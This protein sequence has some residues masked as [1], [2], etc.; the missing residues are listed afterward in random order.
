MFAPA[1]R[2]TLTSTRPPHLSPVPFIKDS[3]PTGASA[4]WQNPAA[5]ALVSLSPEPVAMQHDFPD[6][7]L[8]AEIAVI[9]PEELR[10]FLGSQSPI[11]GRICVDAVVAGAVG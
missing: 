3:L 10:S 8:L 11:S 5:Q 6:G 4:T 1:R 2:H 7:P 9:L